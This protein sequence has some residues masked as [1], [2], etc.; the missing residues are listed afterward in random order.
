M[1]T[2]NFYEQVLSYC[3]N[4]ADNTGVIYE[5]VR[6]S[7]IS[8]GVKSADIMAVLYVLRNE[9][10]IQFLPCEDD[11]GDTVG[12][13]SVLPDAHK[14]FLDKEKERT[15][16]FANWRWNIWASA[17]TTVVSALLGALL[18]RLSHVLWP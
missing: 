10:R 8:P 9:N 2:R 7:D 14:Y 15:G 4:N 5:P 17:A 12:A 16:R 13:I 3:V 11:S 18:A 1:I 6:L